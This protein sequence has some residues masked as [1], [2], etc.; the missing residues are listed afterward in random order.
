MKDATHS[1]RTA[2]SPRDAEAQW[3]QPT[4]LAASFFIHP[5]DEAALRRLKAVPGIDILT[6]KFL[7]FGFESF[8]H[9]LYMGSCI[10]LSKTQLPEIYNLLPPVCEAF[11]ID[12]PEFYLKMNPLPN[13][14]TV[15]DKRIMVVVTSGLL[16]HMKDQTER[17]AVIAHECGH[18]VCRH[19]LYRTM[20]QYLVLLG[21]SFF[22]LLKPFATPL[23]LALNYWSRRSELSADRAGAV[24]AG[25]CE[26]MIRGLL[27]LAGGPDDITHAVD[28]REFAD[29]ARAYDQLLANSKWHKILQSVAIM[30]QDHPFTAV[31][32]RE[33]QAWEQSPAFKEARLV[34]GL[35]GDSCDECL[36]PSCHLPFNPGQKFCRHCGVE[37]P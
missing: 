33:L 19:V 36:C 24:F 15:G 26:P 20:A 1:G 12:E 21:T 14:W 29:Q 16:E 10:R 28:S 32:V 37:L 6:K 30:E 31:R 3:A 22:K 9:G 23:E 8:L 25:G 18:I 27:R 13:A 35:D 34:T 4:K 2:E 5:E 11:G 7:E 17:Q